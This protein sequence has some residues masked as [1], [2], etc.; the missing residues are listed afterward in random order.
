MRAREALPWALLLMV[1]P[2]ILK[3]VTKL[4]GVKSPDEIAADLAGEIGDAI[5]ADVR[6]A[7]GIVIQKLGER[8]AGSL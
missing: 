6:P 4:L 8:I 7:V 3:G 2:K 1:A 5:P